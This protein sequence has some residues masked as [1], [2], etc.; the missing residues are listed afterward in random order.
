VAGFGNEKG[1]RRPG[2]GPIMSYLNSDA[3]IGIVG[4]ELLILEK[5]YI[6]QPTRLS[7]WFNFSGWVGWF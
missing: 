2:E 4:E 3:V 1:D 5:C 6:S 7:L